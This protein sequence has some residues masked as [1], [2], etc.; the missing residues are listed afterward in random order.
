MDRHFSIV[1]SDLVVNN[2]QLSNITGVIAYV[3]PSGG[4]Q[5]SIT[6]QALDVVNGLVHFTGDVGLEW[7]LSDGGIIGSV[8]A[9][10]AMNVSSGPVCDM[11]SVLEYGNN[12][13]YLHSVESTSQYEM[14][15]EGGYGGDV[16]NWYDCTLCG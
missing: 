4:M 12:H 8:H 9:R 2:E 16:H 10:S 7:L 3:V 11:T 13:Y 1:E 14:S 5:G 6:S 15:A